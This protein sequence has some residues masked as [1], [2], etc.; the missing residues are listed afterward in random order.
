MK[1]AG[2][3][4]MVG[5][6]VVTTACNPRK[7]I[8]QKAAAEQKT[9]EKVESKHIFVKDEHEA[10][11]VYQLNDSTAAQTLYDQLPLS[12][13]VE[14]YRHN[15]KIFY[16]SETLDVSETVMAD[17]M[18]GTLAYY[19]P[20][21]DV[22]MFYEEGG[23]GEGLY[24]LGE[25]ISGAD[26]IAD[27][28][29]RLEIGV[30]EE[31]PDQAKKSQENR[32]A[33][34]EPLQEESIPFDQESMEREEDAMLH[35]QIIIGSQTFTATL[36]DTETSRALMDR[37][38]MTVDMDELHGNEK[39]YYFSQGLPIATQQ[40]TPIDTGDIKLFGNDCLV[41]F[42]EDVSNAYAYT[43]LGRVDDPQSFAQALG[44][45]RVQVSFA[46]VD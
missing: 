36:F 38:P 46:Q 37:L 14:N 17:G 16:P 8:E 43:S 4:L 23:A 9:V 5:L 18:V 44:N 3:L 32:T 31:I 10:Y 27:L 35:M 22:V 42:Y 26:Q 25:A 29:G 21:G 11:V 7:Q 30:M 15:E 33:Q 45:G 6:L 13:E 12:V 34:Q 24:A 28:S 41:L 2:I 40:E 39:Y 19:E 1:K 20:W